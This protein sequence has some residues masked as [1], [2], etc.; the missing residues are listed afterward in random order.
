MRAMRAGMRSTTMLALSLATL[1]GCAQSPA[2]DKPNDLETRLLTE[3]VGD[4]DIAADGFSRLVQVRGTIDFG[5]SIRSAYGEGNYRGWLF[6]GTAN[7]RVSLDAMALDESDTVLMLYGPQTASGWSRA[8]PIAVN[9]DYRGSTNSHLEVRLPRAGTYL[10]IV[11]EYYE[12]A[13]EFTLTLACSGAECRTECGTADRCPTGAMCNRVMCVRAPC[14]SFCEAIDPTPPPA[15]GDVCEDT[16][17]CGPRPRNVTLMC[18]DGSV[19]GNT[20]R[21]IRDAS[22]VCGWEQRECPADVVCG[23]RRGNTC[24]ATQFCDFAESAI[25]GRADAT[26]VCHA[27]PTSCTREYAPVCGCNGVTYSNACNANVA[28]VGILHAGRC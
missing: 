11:R 7:A 15:P 16:T 8:R 9:D 21:C 20:G 6:T 4:S 13:G 28:G 3:E 12:S 19:G 10:V 23:G 17:T 24:T 18:S 1:V 14:P 22:L 5:E 27:R 26:G 2:A 25:C